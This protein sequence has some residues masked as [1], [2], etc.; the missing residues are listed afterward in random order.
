MQP[1]FSSLLVHSP[2]LPLE[3]R[4]AL[5]RA[6][7]ARSSLLSEAWRRRAAFLLEDKFDLSECES[8]ELVDL[9]NPC[10]RLAA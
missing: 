1:S 7:A 8:H 10:Q 4:T 6:R 5:V 3:V 2:A 9:P